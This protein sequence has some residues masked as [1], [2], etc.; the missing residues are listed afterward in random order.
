[1]GIIANVWG[2]LPNQLSIQ[3]NFDSA[4]E[5]AWPS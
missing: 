5:C 1:M 4:L 3:S 2:V